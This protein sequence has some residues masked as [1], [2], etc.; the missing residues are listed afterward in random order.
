MSQEQ[1]QPNV[2]DA[3][4]QL[5]VALEKAQKSGVFSFE[6]SS[7]TYSAMLLSKQY[8]QQLIENQKKAQEQKQSVQQNPTRNRSARRCDTDKCRGSIGTGLLPWICQCRTRE[9]LLQTRD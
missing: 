2:L 5:Y 8:F 9:R 6:E 7:K 4:N 1:K 3:M